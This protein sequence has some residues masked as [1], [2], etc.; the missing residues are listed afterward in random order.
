MRSQDQSLTPLGEPLSHM[1]APKQ[2]PPPPQMFSACLLG[3]PL[4]QEG[5][6]FPSS[7]G[8]LT[9]KQNREPSLCPG[10]RTHDDINKSVNI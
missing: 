10:R 7:S 5:K 9:T 1:L 4:Q 8:E 3:I 2:E 6:P